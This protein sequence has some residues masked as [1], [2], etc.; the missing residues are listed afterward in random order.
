M[1]RATAVLLGLILTVSVACDRAK[2]QGSR[3]E[4]ART[5]DSWRADVG[6]FRVAKSEVAAPWQEIIDS[7][8]T[9]RA[10]STSLSTERSYLR[11]LSSE[12]L[13]GQL[14]FWEQDSLSG[15]VL[16][17]FTDMG[18]DLMFELERS[19]SGYAGVIWQHSDIDRSPFRVGTV[20]MSRV[21]C[22]LSGR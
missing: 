20:S 18:S 4:P 17:H 12:Y 8:G 5:G 2:Q 11:R 13:K 10:D 21:A 3:G 16:W 15:G 14:N 6:C 9:V 22:D 19:T 7:L 1:M